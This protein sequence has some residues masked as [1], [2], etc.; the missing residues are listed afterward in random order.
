MKGIKM[1][2]QC[3]V[4]HQVEYSTRKGSYFSDLRTKAGKNL[5]RLFIRINNTLEKQKIASKRRVDLKE[6]AG[7]SDE[8]LK[9]IGISRDNAEWAFNQ[10][11]ADKNSEELE[12][13]L[14]N[15]KTYK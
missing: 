11:S 2:I 13:F 15:K 5:D 10:V 4:E 12:N 8:T 3:N 6:L 1:T 14:E 7:L 9:D